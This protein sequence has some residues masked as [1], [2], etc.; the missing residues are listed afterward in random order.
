MYDIM[1]EGLKK[2]EDVYDG[3]D[4]IKKDAMLKNEN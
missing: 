2:E 1:L 3:V 4:N